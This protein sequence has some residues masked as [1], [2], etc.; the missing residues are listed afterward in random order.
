[1]PDFHDAL[2]AGKRVERFFWNR[3]KRKYKH[4]V[5]IEG[6]FKPFDIYIADN[7]KRWEVKCDMKSNYTGNF[8]IEVEHYGKPSALMT[9]EAEFWVFYDAKDWIAVKPQSMKDLIL[10]HGY[11]LISTIG[12]GDTHAKKCYL[13]PKDDI[14]SIATNIVPCDEDEI[15]KHDNS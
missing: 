1:M 8:L 12:N 5:M 14:K 15:L 11:K 13:V 4:P 3:L 7:H 6:S 10:S 2:M 9:T